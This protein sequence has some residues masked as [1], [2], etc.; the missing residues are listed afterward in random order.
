MVRNDIESKISFAMERLFTVYRAL[1]WEKVKELNLSPIQILFILYFRKYPEKMRNVSAIS[2]EFGL[3]KATVSDAISALERKKIVYKEKNRKDKR[4]STINLTEKGMKL[5]ESLELWDTPI[6][7]I[8]KNFSET[9]K[10]Q[11]FSFFTK[12]INS[13]RNKGLINPVRMCLTC[14]HFKKISISDTETSYFCELTGK[15]F[16]GKELKID[17]ITH[18]SIYP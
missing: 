11:I 17:C 12:L 15:S 4:F 7:E 5:A 3:T 10:E 8:L 2:S 6:K 16:S 13:L 18:S 1:I 9:E 14:S